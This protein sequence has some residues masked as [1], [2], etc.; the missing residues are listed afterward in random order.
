MV[1]M[2]DIS[3]RC[4]VSVS[5]VSK[6]LNDHS[7]ISEETKKH[8]KEVARQMGYLPNASAKQLKTNRSYNIG[9]LMMDEAGMG[10]THDFYGEILENIREVS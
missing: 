1:S 7:D 2:K 3:Q 10:L 8:I 9:V 5:T 6:A 4:G